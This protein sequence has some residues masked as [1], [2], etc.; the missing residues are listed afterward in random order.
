M[1]RLAPRN[2]VPA[3]RTAPASFGPKVLPLKP[4]VP[5]CYTPT[6][7]RPKTKGRRTV[8]RLYSTGVPLITRP[9][10]GHRLCRGVPICPNPVSP[11]PG[12]T[13]SLFDLLRLVCSP[14]SN[15][16]AFP[17]S[18]PAHS[19]RRDFAIS[20]ALFVFYLLRQYESFQLDLD[21][22]FRS[23]LWKH[24]LSCPFPP[25]CCRSPCG[26]FSPS[27]STV[28]RRHLASQASVTTYCGPRFLSSD[29]LGCRLLLVWTPRPVFDDHVEPF[30]S[31]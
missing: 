8:H 24:L 9:S 13:P 30:L 16:L 2:S 3:F 12:R 27:S 4:S 10:A 29:G 28:I 20:V 18:F 25:S 7:R 6:P 14:A 11:P 19:P 21:G 31:C 1:L 15:V 23:V 26:R 22:A 17:H 5:P